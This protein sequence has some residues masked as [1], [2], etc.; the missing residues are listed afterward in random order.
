MEYLSETSSL[1]CVYLYV[2]IVGSTQD[3]GRSTKVLC[4]PY[5]DSDVNTIK[6]TKRSVNKHVDGKRNLL[7][8]KLPVPTQNHEDYRGPGRGEE[9]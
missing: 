7:L 1:V 5:K 6:L 2:Y 3:T 8:G 4:D 9:P